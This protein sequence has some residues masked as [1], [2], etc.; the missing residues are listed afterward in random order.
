MWLMWDVL[1]ML[2]EVE[3]GVG[4]SVRVSGANLYSIS[5][6]VVVMVL[7]IWCMWVV[8]VLVLFMCFIV[9]LVIGFLFVVRKT[10]SCGGETAAC[11]TDGANEDEIVIL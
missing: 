7:K 9:G 5:S 2:D 1:W 4:V 8:M 10:M 11:G 3:C 6:V